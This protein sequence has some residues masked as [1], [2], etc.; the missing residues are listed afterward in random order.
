MLTDIFREESKRMVVFRLEKL[1]IHSLFSLTLDAERCEILS[2]L[3][4][5]YFYEII[6]ICSLFL[7]SP[8]KS[9]IRYSLFSCE[10]RPI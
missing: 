10:W 3:I 1:Q 9:D 8:V 6:A 7:Q 2:A 4:G 5:K